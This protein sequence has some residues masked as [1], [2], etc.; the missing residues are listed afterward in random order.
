[1]FHKESRQVQFESLVYSSEG[2]SC[3]GFYDSLFLLASNVVSFY[4][5]AIQLFIRD[6]LGAYKKTFLGLFWIILSPFIAVVSWLF[7]NY[8]GI[9]QPGKLDVPYPVYILMGTS[10]WNLFIGFYQAS[11]STLSSGQSFILQVK[12]PHDILLLKNIIEQIVNFVIVI[13][14]QYLFFIYF[15]IYVSWKILL[16]PIAILPFFFFSAGLGLIMT[17]FGTVVPELRRI[18]DVF[19]NMVIF[20]TPVIYSPSAL[21]GKLRILL[22]INP[23]TYYIDFARSIMLN[24]PLESPVGTIISVIFSFFV[25]I[26]SLRFFYRS[27]KL[28]IERLF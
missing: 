9:L 19:L 20:I 5:L 24:T 18:F 26:F 12:Y 2:A 8:T 1:M 6:F 25:F 13:T 21:T 22:Y 10:L 15:D 16:L 28:V 14:I 3:I 7:M 11:A 17:V 23:V 27:E 4:P